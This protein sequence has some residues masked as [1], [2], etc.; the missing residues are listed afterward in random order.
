M[1]QITNPLKQFFR[2]P[3]IYLRLPSTGQY[4]DSAAISLPDNQELP[5]FP[6]TAIDEITYRT[7]DALF[8][9]QAVVN[10]IQSCVP[11]IQDAWKTPSTDFNAILIAIRIA[12]Y[13]HDMDMT[14]KCPSCE[15]ES[16]FTI[17]LR[18]ILDKIKSGDYAESLKQGDLEITFTPIS[19]KHQNEI[20]LKQ[21]EQQ[22]KI[23]QIQDSAELDDEQ[24]LKQLNATLQDITQLTVEMLNH[25]VASIRTPQ[26]LVT[27]SEFIQEFLVNCDRKFYTELRD[28]VVK[29]RQAGEIEPFDTTCPNCSHKWKQTMTLDQ[30]A[31]FGVA[32]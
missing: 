8:N 17:D 18:K 13:G 2:Q 7:P 1:P 21:F 23:Q 15:T 32:S 12:S 19:F 25:S 5:I 16:D 28:H 6:M 4:W 3:A 26:S 20:N 14:V 11:A 31:F 27:E 24:K 22:R 10:V 9:G 30:A 29:L